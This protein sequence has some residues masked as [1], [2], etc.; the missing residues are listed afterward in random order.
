MKQYI[1][2]DL[3]ET[4]NIIDLLEQVKTSN[5]GI[6]L[7]VIQQIDSLNQKIKDSINLLED[8]NL[9]VDCLETN[10]ELVDSFELDKLPN[11]DEIDFED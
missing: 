2:I 9:L 11:Q 3:K 10:F 4:K 1:Q 7:M 6:K 8:E 5:A